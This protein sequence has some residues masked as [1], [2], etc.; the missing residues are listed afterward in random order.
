LPR[1]VDDWVETVR[2]DVPLPP[3]DSVRLVGL[4]DTDG[5]DGEMLVDSVIVPE[6]PPWLDSVILEDPD[7]PGAILSDAG[8]DE[9]VKS[10]VA[11]CVTVRAWLVDAV[12][13]TESCTVNRTV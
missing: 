1:G 10:G 4:R 7:A 6:K 2:V 11:G 12:A 5:P 13:P 9:I 3:D 8:L